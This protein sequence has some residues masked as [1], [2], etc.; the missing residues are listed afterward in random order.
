MKYMLLLIA[1]V[2]LPAHAAPT[3][4]VS[5]K[6]WIHGSENC[7]SNEDPAIDV[8]Q[9]DSDTFVLRQNKCINYEAPFIYLMFGEHTLF[10]QDTGATE[11]SDEFP[12]YATIKKIA[13]QW[14]GNNGVDNL[15]ILVTHSHSHLD[16]RAGDDQFRN[17]PNV[18]LIE[19]N[20][21]A[22]IDYFGFTQW[23]NGQ[24]VIDLGN[25][26][27]TVMPI[28]GHQAESLA[29]Y[30]SRTQWLLR[31]THSIQEDSMYESGMNINQVF[32]SWLILPT[33]TPSRLLW[34]LTLR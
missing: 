34:V 16:H 10:V 1:I 2:N 18:S 33:S 27:L 20:Q 28:P 21:D 22:V 6:S 32:K 3:D 24:A 29:V 30:D 4:I 26:Q 7:R 23:P 31:G 9:V 11:S 19:A 12:I 25:R 13:E 15:H 17:Q 5:Q 8:L 14:Q